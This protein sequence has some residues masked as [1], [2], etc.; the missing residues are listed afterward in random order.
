MSRGQGEG[1]W[2]HS[3]SLL[4]DLEAAAFVVLKLCVCVSI[5]IHISYISVD[6]DMPIICLATES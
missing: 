2:L 1:L 5:Y 3:C 4:E 6:L